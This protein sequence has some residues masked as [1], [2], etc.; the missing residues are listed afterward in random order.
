M[1]IQ[2]AHHARQMSTAW[3]I[4]MKASTPRTP[5]VA[6]MR[7]LLS[8]SETK[9]MELTLDPAPVKDLEE[10]FR[11]PEERPDTLASKTEIEVLVTGELQEPNGYDD[12]EH[13]IPLLRVLTLVLS[14]LEVYWRQGVEVE[15]KEPSKL[16]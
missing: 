12:A 14:W 10:S 2:Q 15:D 3:K 11:P 1:Y 8:P 9:L 6:L 13:V 16:V 4:T 7:V 5:L